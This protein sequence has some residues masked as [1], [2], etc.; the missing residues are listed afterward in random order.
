[1]TTT[2]QNITDF[3]DEWLVANRDWVSDVSVDFALDVRNM[4]IQLAESN[5]PSP[6]ASKRDLAVGDLLPIDPSEL[7]EQLEVWRS[8]RRD[9]LYR[10][11]DAERR[12]LAD[13]RG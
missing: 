6:S 5:S 13:F 12:T 1:M 7:S 8:L 3:I 2:P 4:L 9:L 10:Y 11:P